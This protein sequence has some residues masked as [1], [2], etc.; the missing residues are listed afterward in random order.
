MPP[1]GAPGSSGWLSAPTRETGPL[2]AQPLP[3]V[4]EPAASKAAD[5]PEFDHQ[6]AF[7]MLPLKYAIAHAPHLRYQFAPIGTHGKKMNSH[8]VEKFRHLFASLPEGAGCKRDGSDGRRMLPPL[9]I[10]VARPNATTHKPRRESVPPIVGWSMW[11][12][13]GD[14]VIHGANRTTLQDGD[15]VTICN[16]WGNTNANLG[17]DHDARSARPALMEAYYRG[18]SESPAIVEA[19]AAGTLAVSVHIRNGDTA[20]L[21]TTGN[22]L[23]YTRAA[24]LMP[25]MRVVAELPPGCASLLI[26]TELPEDTQARE[27]TRWFARA[28]LNRTAVR[29]LDKQ[30]CDGPCAFHTL[31]QSDVLVSVRSAF[32]YTAA[33][34]TKD[35]ATLAFAGHD[36][37]GAAESKATLRFKHWREHMGRPYVMTPAQLRAALTSRLP[38][39]CHLK[40][41]HAGDGADGDRVAQLSGLQRQL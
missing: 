14:G 26:V 5:S 40:E 12:I 31:A 34:V 13:I 9:C 30:L 21:R 4:L 29:V 18:A 16:A 20:K 36:A 19:H 23:R 28:S 35:T 10:S 27:F 39:R 32:S 15:T 7:R 22:K 1:Q 25:M 37:R 6:V 2:G 24:D 41:V 3:R 38:A 8:Q 33:M 11:T 17:I